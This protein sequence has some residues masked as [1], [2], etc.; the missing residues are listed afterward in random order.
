[1]PGQAG[2]VDEPRHYTEVTGNVED[3]VGD[4]GV[5]HVTGDNNH[6][7]TGSAG[8]IG[9]LLGSAGIGQIAQGEVVTSAC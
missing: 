8:G 9:H 5:R 6:P 3:A 2:V 7:R 4:G 1:M